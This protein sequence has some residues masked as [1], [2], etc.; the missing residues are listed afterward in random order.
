MKLNIRY[1]NKYKILALTSIVIITFIIFPIMSGVLSFKSAK[2]HEESSIIKTSAAG[3]SDIEFLQSNGSIVYFDPI[4]LEY[5]Q[6][7]SSGQGAFELRIHAPNLKWNQRFKVE[8]AGYAPFF[9]MDIAYDITMIDDIPILG[10]LLGPIIP[11]VLF[12]RLVPDSS[13]KL[14]YYLDEDDYNSEE[15][16]YSLTPSPDDQFVWNPQIFL[17]DI[18]I[19]WALPFAEVL[20]NATLP[21]SFNVNDV[22]YDITNKFK[23]TA[24]QCLF[25][26]W[27]FK[28]NINFNYKGTTVSFLEIAVSNED[29]TPPT[30]SEPVILKAFAGA[31][32]EVIVDIV[33]EEFGSGVD[34]SS[35]YMVYSVD[36][37]SWRRRAFLLFNGSYHGDLPQEM[38]AME[39]QYYIEFGDIA[40]N[41]AI[42][43]IYVI[44]TEFYAVGKFGIP[45]GGIL[46]TAG[47]VG[48][49]TGIYY[50]R[51]APITNMPSRRKLKSSRDK[52]LSKDNESSESP[53]SLRSIKS[54]KG[55]KSSGV[56]T[57]VIKK[58][59]KYLK[60]IW[61]H[62]R[63]RFIESIEQERVHHG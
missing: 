32:F 37:G 8:L 12:L 55:L 41:I 51:N 21:V 58:P 2:E 39:I 62:N 18:D 56:D 63:E 45:I 53:K 26:W 23:I 16:Y 5:K 38:L 44:H 59:E 61:P 4:D 43:P 11:D 3:I 20:L 57:I 54:S 46:L 10:P 35:V 28:S 22:K 31:N 36:G 25:G 24:E 6:S 47:I 29:F 42:T 19:S 34:E 14:I 50:R 7:F 33:D 9:K 60:Y 40:G 15:G 27:I 1:L 48:G 30:C 52:T 13:N 49:I 17:G